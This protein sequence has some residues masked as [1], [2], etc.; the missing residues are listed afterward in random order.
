MVTSW[1]PHDYLMV[2]SWLKNFQKSRLSCWVP[3]GTDMLSREE[4]TDVTGTSPCV[5]L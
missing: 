5:M 2:T 3:L 4:D 1:L